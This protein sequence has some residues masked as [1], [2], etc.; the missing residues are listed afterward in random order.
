MFRT[1]PRTCCG[2]SEGHVP[3]TNNND[4]NIYLYLFNIYK[5]KLEKI[6][7]KDFSRQIKI[8]SECKNSDDYQ[9]MSLEDQ[10]KLYIDLISVSQK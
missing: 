10:N 7:K 4:N 5:A 6:E 2:D 3:D 1:C 8:I 9:K